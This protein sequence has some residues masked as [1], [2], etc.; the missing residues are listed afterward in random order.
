MLLFPTIESLF[1]GPATAWPRVVLEFLFSR[2]TDR[3][4]HASSTLAAFFFGNNVP[5]ALAMPLIEGCMEL[6]S[7]DPFL[8]AVYDLYNAWAHTTCPRACAYYDVRIMHHRWTN[9]PFGP[10][11]AIDPQE[12]PTGPVL[13]G[14]GTQ[15]DGVAMRTP[16]HYARATAHVF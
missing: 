11:T 7:G 2:P 1:G 12:G 13:M 15:R 14:F 16:L 10:H 6:D 5:C 8:Y 3:S 4:L 9:T